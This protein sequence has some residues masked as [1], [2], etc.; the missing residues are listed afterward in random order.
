[1]P[2]KKTDNRVA[3]L[4]DTH[5]GVR[6]G[7]QIFHE[8]FER[9]YR[10]TFFPTL[11]D[12]GID[13]IIHLGDVF[14]VRKG[15]DYWSL[16]WAKRVVFQP[17]LD[18]G[19]EFHIIVGN[20]DAFYKQSLKINSPELNLTEFPN[21]HVYS[22][23]QTAKVKGTDVFFIPW[24]CDDNADLFLEQRDQSKA[25]VAM[26][27][28]EI[29][30]FY[31]NS[32]FQVQHGLDHNV[33]SQFNQVF[34]GHFHKKN[35]SGNITYLG[36]TYQLYWNDE[37]DT[38]GFHIYD[39]KSGDLEQIANPNSMFHKI[40][41]NEGEK[42]LINPTKYSNSY[43]K[44][45]VEGTSTPAKLNTFVD[46]LYKVGVHDI[47]IIE[48]VDLSIDDDVEVEAEDTLTT[49]TNYVNA[50]EE[51]VNKENLVEIFKSLYVESQEI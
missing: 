19:I 40:Y 30:G 48:N 49:L 42:K 31:A 1:M 22:E 16:E 20:H 41:Y 44:I 39:L 28:L 36:N 12:R 15:I 38:R 3:L 21:I 47:K 33:L 4:T 51:E 5:F 29:A 17:A 26:G 23:P 50:L 27:H 25:K 34:S 8:Y 11:R 45:I 18:A 24:I 2:R 13:T 46:N 7:S 6:K 37:G 43:V 10:D 14:D 32:N 35:S 9:F